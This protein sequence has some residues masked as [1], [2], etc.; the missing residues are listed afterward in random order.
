MRRMQ[1]YVVDPNDPRAP[2]QEVWDQLSEEEREHIV[3]SLPTGDSDRRAAIE[4]YSAAID[5]RLASLS[6]RIAAAQAAAAEARIA[7]ALAEL[8]RLRSRSA[9]PT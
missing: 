7:E 2:S 5:A 9:P 8:E 1:R 3:Q 4:A 6:A